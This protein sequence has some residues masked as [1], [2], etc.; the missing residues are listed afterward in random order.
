MSQVIFCRT[1]RVRVQS[2][3]G[4]SACT[5]FAGC[6]AHTACPEPPGF[7][8]RQLQ[9]SGLCAACPPARHHHRKA[10][11]VRLV[12]SLAGDSVL[13]FGAHRV[14]RFRARLWPLHVPLGHAVTL[15]LHACNAKINLA[16]RAPLQSEILPVF[17]CNAGRSPPIFSKN[18]SVISAVDTSID[19]MML[20]KNHVTNLPHGPLLLGRVRVATRAPNALPPRPAERGA[21]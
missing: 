15:A 10:D 5:V 11:L 13:Y 4:G 12:E 2:E 14:D 16:G 9:H 3:T 21:P 19:R 6:D 7:A 17:A 8:S 18:A 1:K 20:N